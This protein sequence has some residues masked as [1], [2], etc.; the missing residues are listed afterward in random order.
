VSILAPLCITFILVLVYFAQ[1]C[2]VA[3]IKKT[4]TNSEKADAL[5]DLALKLLLARDKDKSKLDKDSVLAKLVEELSQEL[6]STDEIYHSSLNTNDEKVSIDWGA[7]Q[8]SVGLK[9]RQSSM[10]ASVDG[11]PSFPSLTQ[12]NASWAASGDAGVEMKPVGSPIHFLSPSGTS[13]LKRENCV[14]MNDYE[15]TPALMQLC[16]TV[17]ALR[18]SPKITQRKESVTAANGTGSTRE[19]S[20][21]DRMESGEGKLGTAI[22]A[23]EARKQLKE[24]LRLD[25]PALF[26]LMDKMA[27]EL[28]AAQSDRSKNVWSVVSQ[29]AI[30]RTVQVYALSTKDCATLYY[31][32]YTLLALHAAAVLNISTEE[33]KSNRASGVGYMVGNKVLTL[34]EIRMKL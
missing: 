20:S 19:D 17:P 34:A 28:E 6:D 10:Q 12:V 16:G 27:E 8:T 13:A 2:G 21:D 11:A 9:K 23:K 15:V 7:L 32:L 22:E 33:V 26:A 24:S 29:S 25:V 31:K 1:V 14:I 4:Y 30:F 5:A 3:S 18:K